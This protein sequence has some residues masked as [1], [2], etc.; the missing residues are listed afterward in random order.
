M[1]EREEMKV[2][3][4]SVESIVIGLA[5]LVVIQSILRITHPSSSELFSGIAVALFFG[6][7]LVSIFQP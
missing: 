1:D 4:L 6:V 7:L 3:A 5:C 2:G